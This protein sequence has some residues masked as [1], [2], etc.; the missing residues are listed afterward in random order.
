M[1]SGQNKPHRVFKWANAENYLQGTGLPVSS[2]YQ[3]Q[4]PGAQEHSNEPQV[5]N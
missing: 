4:Y 2:I 1:K 5:T 3:S